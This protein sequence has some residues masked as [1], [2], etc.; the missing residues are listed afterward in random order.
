MFTYVSTVLI[1]AE[2][3]YVSLGWMVNVGPS[4]YTSA[5]AEFLSF[6]DF[7]P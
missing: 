5:L 6:N 3:V 7:V 2:N 4:A 1:Y